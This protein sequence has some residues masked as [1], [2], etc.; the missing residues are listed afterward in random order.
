MSISTSPEMFINMKS[1][2]KKE[3]QD[4]DAFLLNELDKL[5]Y[6]VTINGVYISSYYTGHINYWKAYIP[7]QVRSGEVID[8]FINPQLRDN[9][10]MIAEYLEQA[11]EK[12][13][14]YY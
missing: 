12:R 11:K 5:Q 4:Y 13:K 2:P 6:G 8:K 7:Q 1:I 9:E 10:W 14:D 3:T